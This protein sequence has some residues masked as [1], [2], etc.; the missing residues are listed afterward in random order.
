MTARGF[1]GAEGVLRSYQKV[2]V[3]VF[4][5]FCW[6]H[7]ADFNSS[8]PNCVTPNIADRQKRLMLFN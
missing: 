4:G 6:I 2:D 1:A 8:F 3:V 5:T 7:G